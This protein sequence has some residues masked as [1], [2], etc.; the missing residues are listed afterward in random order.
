MSAALPKSSQRNS[1][2]VAY[3]V[4]ALAILC[5]PLIAMQFTGEVNWQVGDFVVMAVMLAALGAAIELGLR[6]FRSHWSRAISV[7][8]AL[9]AF[10]FIWAMLA[11][12]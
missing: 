5:V 1:F 9:S 4:I 8:I 6:V 11:T 12:G 7:A 10:L 3:A 2:R